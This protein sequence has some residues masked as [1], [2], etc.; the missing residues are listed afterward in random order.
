ML[1]YKSDAS[2]SPHS[3]PNALS[4]SSVSNAQPLKAQ[5]IIYKKTTIIDALSSDPRYSTFIR[6]LQRLHLIIE[7]NGYTN[8]T[9]L[10]PTN[11]AFERYEASLIF[12]P[13][14]ISDSLD[15]LDTP[16]KESFSPVYKQ[17]TRDKM[18]LSVI[19][20]GVYGSSAWVDG[21]VWETNSGWRP[22]SLNKARHIDGIML[23][24]RID[25]TGRIMI[26]N[27]EVQDGE[28]WCTS[29]VVM[30]LSG[31]ILPPPKLEDILLNGFNSTALAK[32]TQHQT[33]PSNKYNHFR[34]ALYVTKWSNVIFYNQISLNNSND[35]SKL[36]KHTVWVPSDFELMS[37]FSWSQW[38]YLTRVPILN[39]DE[40][41]KKSAFEDL[42]TIMRNFVSPASWSL[43]R[44]GPGIHQIP[45]IDDD[46]ISSKKNLTLNVLSSNNASFDG[47]KIRISDCL[48]FDGIAHKISLQNSSISSQISWTP[49]KIIL[50][51]NATRFVELMIKYGLDDYLDGSKKGSWTFLVPTNNAIEQFEHFSDFFSFNDIKN[52]LLY[53]IVN[54]NIVSSDLQDGQLLKSEYKPSSLNNHKQIIRVSTT[55]SKSYLNSST[56]KNTQRDPKWI[57]FNGA[58]LEIETS[59]PVNE[60]TSI[61]L[62]SESLSL[63]EPLINSLVKDLN[64]SSYIGMLSIVPNLL[65]NVSNTSSLSFLVPNNDAFL[66]LGLAYNYLTRP[67]DYE[68]KLD[69]QKLATSHICDTVIYSDMVNSN[70]T[71]NSDNQDCKSVIEAKSLNQNSIFFSKDA[72]TNN[73]V[74]QNNLMHKSNVYVNRGI[75]AVD[76]DIPFSSG[77]IHRLSDSF[78]YPENL[79][80]TPQKL[81]RGMN[82]FTFKCLLNMFNM[83]GI[84]DLEYNQTFKAET[85]TSDGTDTNNIIG[86]SFLVPSDQL[87]GNYPPFKEYMRRNKRFPNATSNAEKI[88]GLDA[89]D[90]DNDNP[91][92]NKT[93]QEISD[94]LIRVLKLHILPIRNTTNDN[95]LAFDES[96]M[97]E[98]E[99]L[100]EHVTIKYHKTIT[101]EMFFVIDPNLNTP[102]PSYPIPPIGMP[103]EGDNPKQNSNFGIVMR[104]GQISSSYFVNKD[105]YDNSLISNYN[106]MLYEI[107]T[108]LEAP[109]A[110]SNGNKGSL[111]SKISWQIF[112]FFTVLGLIGA[113]SG[114]ICLWAYSLRTL[115]GNF[116]LLDLSLI[117]EIAQ[118][119]LE[120]QTTTIVEDQDPQYKESS[121][122]PNNK[123]A[124]TDFEPTYSTIIAN[125]IDTNVSI[126]IKFNSGTSSSNLTNFATNLGQ[127]SSAHS[128]KKAKLARKPKYKSAAFQATK[129]SAASILSNVKIL[130][131]NFIAKLDLWVENVNMNEIDD[132]FKLGLA[133]THIADCFRTFSDPKS[134]LLESS[135][136]HDTS[137]DLISILKTAPFYKNQVSEKS[138][139]SIPSKCA[140]YTSLLEPSNPKSVDLGELDTNT[141]SSNSVQIDTGLLYNSLTRSKSS[142]ES[143]TA[144]KNCFNI[145]DFYSHQVEAFDIIEQNKNLL[146]TTSTASGKSAIFQYAIAKSLLDSVYNFGLNVDPKLDD[147]DSMANFNQD[148]SFLDESLLYNGQNSDFKSRNQDSNISNYRNDIQYNHYDLNNSCCSTV[149]MI[150]PYKALTQNQLASIKKLLY[151]IPSLFEAGVIVDVFDGDTQSK[152]RIQI[153]RRVNVLLTNPDTLHCSILPNHT[154]WNRFFANL[155]LVIIDE[156]HVYNGMFG[157][158][159]TMILSRLRRLTQFYKNSYGKYTQNLNQKAQFVLCSATVDDPHIFANRLLPSEKFELVE[160]S[161]AP[162]PELDIVLWNSSQ[163]AINEGKKNSNVNTSNSIN[164]SDN[165]DDS[166][167][168]ALYPK[169]SDKIGDV[170]DLSIFLLGMNYKTLTRSECELIYHKVIKTLETNIDGK[171]LVKKVVS[172]RAGY[173]TKD[174]RKLESQMFCN[175][176]SLLISTNALELGIDIGS[177]DAVVESDDQRKVKQK[178]T[179]VL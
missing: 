114:L 7:F 154:K 45:M 24:S 130:I 92:V 10:A 140:Q 164:E 85:P 141:A 111:I 155:S 46:A 61:Y 167:D 176:I 36:I 17:M 88:F 30:P 22:D 172:Y 133:K 161:S 41:L 169:T 108:V 143:L 122:V 131:G 15:S 58:P 144:V 128:N 25:K 69:L 26:G 27:I 91:W 73:L 80:I 126:I 148:G 110:L 109:D 49:K 39:L 153:P 103:Q 163:M 75:V 146:V 40:K 20:D 33:D 29:G 51:L 12:T 79:L 168:N 162:R 54:K 97:F 1:Y 43:T 44:L 175:S 171:N 105:A 160:K 28:I 84:L 3:S 134:Y 71:Q 11:A 151:S 50:G 149:L 64:Y 38:N 37:A 86:Y 74:I 112:L 89:N 135:N 156:M 60:Y 6:Y 35:N 23:K 81:L 62:L 139:I 132:N 47:M 66:K 5:S 68:A 96:Q 77:V 48:A 78:L 173:S 16:N 32:T 63:P 70:C 13:E 100:L 94:Y 19:R 115:N 118:E 2:L 158:H 76:Q 124:I 93:N 59:T 120:L 121:V 145:L 137:Q 125:M 106:F 42:K 4:L 67:N 129:I 82:S 107:D 95:S 65:K 157:Q 119:E 177:L 52:W 98:Y 53:H 127:N 56:R 166:F 152:E 179:I 147:F 87:W 178:K 21:M 14:D 174:R 57:T 8:V 170:V 150:F 102:T 34:A 72:G 55:S 113:L 90:F 117:K 99:T 138:T 116:N 83:S 31:V 123:N 136:K 9:I 18:L 159:F 104:Q 165:Q 101:R 142:L